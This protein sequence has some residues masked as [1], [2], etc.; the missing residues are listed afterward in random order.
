[1]KKLALAVFL[2]FPSFAQAADTTWVQAVAGGY[3]ARLVTSA[4][5]CPALRTDK[6]DVSMTVRAAA[7]S[8]FALTCSALIPA[9]TTRAAIGGV[10]LPVPVAHP[11]RIL[12]LGDTGCRLKGVAL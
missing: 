10:H 1:M 3:E 5:N 6:G 8:N 12:V 9:G 2:L 4:P 7:D 11:Q